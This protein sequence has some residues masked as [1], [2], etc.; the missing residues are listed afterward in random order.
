MARRDEQK[1][2]LNGIANG[3]SRMKV[4]VTG[5]EIEGGDE[6][7]SE[8]FKAIRE[9]SQAISRSTVLPSG[10]AS[11]PALGAP[12]PEAVGVGAAMETEP[13]ED[14]ANVETE[15]SSMEDASEEEISSANGAR[16]KRNYNFKTPTFLN[17]LDVTKAKKSLKD[18]VAE[19]SPPDV[20]SKYLA[21]VYW[22]QKYMD[23]AEVTIDHVY[24]VFDLLGWKT[25]MPSN[26]SVPLRDLKSKRHMLT[27][28]SGSEGYK[29]NFKGEQ[30][31]EGMGAAK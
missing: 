13:A 18:F 4:F 10:S 7:L 25:E 17:D 14:S 24:T 31:V 12:K 15:E 9:L 22:L 5:F 23:V 11:R 6:I 30:Y 20:M 2:K 28:E 26:P 8:G 19:K 29:V 27:R 3:K 1:T 16:Q 21:V